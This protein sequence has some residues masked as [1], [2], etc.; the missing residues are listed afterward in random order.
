MTFCLF[1]LSLNLTVVTCW[2]GLRRTS[3]KIS[4]SNPSYLKTLEFFEDRQDNRFPPN[5]TA[6]CLFRLT[7]L[8]AFLKLEENKGM[9]EP[10]SDKWHRMEQK[11]F[12]KYPF[13]VFNNVVPN[14]NLD[15]SGIEKV[16][17][18]TVNTS[19]KGTDLPE[20]EGVDAVEVSGET[21]RTMKKK[22]KS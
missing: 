5:L 6:D 4:L 22:G 3:V 17:S 7:S 1:G 18:F 21:Q 2:I 16:L 20:A 9:I 8:R 11:Y 19:G 15:V 10:F 14:K 13:T 12:E